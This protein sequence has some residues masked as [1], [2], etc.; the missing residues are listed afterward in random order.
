M[1]D[2]DALKSEV[3]VVIIHTMVMPL[4]IHKQYSI[5]YKVHTYTGLLRHGFLAA[6]CHFY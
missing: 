3:V 4:V 5:V 1:C 2:S 6:E